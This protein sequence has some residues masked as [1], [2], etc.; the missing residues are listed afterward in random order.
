LISTRAVSGCSRET[1]HLA[2]SSRL[3]PSVADVDLLHEM[4]D[5][6]RHD[7]AR[8]VHPVAARQDPAL[9]RRHRLGDQRRFKFRFELG[10]FL[11]KFDQSVALFLPLAVDQR[12]VERLLDFSDLAS[13]AAIF[14][15]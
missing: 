4:G 2:R 10:P 9:A 5:A 7:G 1:S 8:R 12:A 3:T 11:A 15:R 13:R 14:D 6:R